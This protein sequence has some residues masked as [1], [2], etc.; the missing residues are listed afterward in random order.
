MASD[1]IEND[2]SV[3]DQPQRQSVAEVVDDETFSML[4]RR[5]VEGLSYRDLGKLYGMHW[6]TIYYRLKSAVKRLTDVGLWPQL[7]VDTKS[8]TITS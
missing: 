7:N 1:W 4:A 2:L 6:N 5:H 3:L 8:C